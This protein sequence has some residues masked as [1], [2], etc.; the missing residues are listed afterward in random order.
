VGE[1]LG[2]RFE[3]DSVAE[4]LEAANVVQGGGSGSVPVL[5]VVASQVVE[6]GVGVR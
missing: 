6:E 4:C 3:G 2:D 5:L 1:L